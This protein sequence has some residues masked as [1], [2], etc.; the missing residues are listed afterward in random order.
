M[1]RTGERACYSVASSKRNFPPRGNK[2]PRRGVGTHAYP[3]GRDKVDEALSSRTRG[4]TGIG[5]DIDETDL[6]AYVDGRLS[7]ERRAQVEAAAA[8]S[9]DL[10][11]RLHAIRASVLPYATAFAAETLPPVPPRLNARVAQLLSADPH[12]WQRRGFRWPR[13]AAAFAAG[14]LCCAVA[15]KLLSTGPSLL[16]SGVPP[17]I[18]AVADY[19]QLYSRETLANVSE[20]RQ[21]SERVISDLRTV[22]GLNVRVPDLR[23]AGLTFKRVQR[24]S[25]NHQAVVQMAYLAERGE[26]VAVCVTRDSRPDEAPRLHQMG[27]LSSVAWR[28][29]NLGY[30]LLGKG[31]PQALMALGRRLANGEPPAL[32]GRSAS[33]ARKTDA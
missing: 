15:L 14:A 22:D 19:Q 20:D 13:L 18:Q 29:D 28:H 9:P 7:A 2:A 17:W 11:A 8:G 3:L 23:S 24:L 4:V 6:L 31:S 27:E 33:S 10:A 21:L 30:V 5:M 25:F 12:S 26:P 32:Y 1:A 16:P